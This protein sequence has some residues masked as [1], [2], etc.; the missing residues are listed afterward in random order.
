MLDAINALL[1]AATE[2]AE[3]LGTENVTATDELNNKGR[4]ASAKSASLREALDYLRGEVKAAEALGTI[5][6][7]GKLKLDAEERLKKATKEAEDYGTSVTQ[8]LKAMEEKVNRI[9]GDLRV[10]L[11][12]VRMLEKA[13]TYHAAS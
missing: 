10:A 11:G 5:D 9:R 12:Q 6:A 4:E 3:K 2:E 7:D 1:K 8:E 13:R